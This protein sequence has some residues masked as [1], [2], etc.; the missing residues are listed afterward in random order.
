MPNPALRVLTDFRQWGTTLPVW[1]GRL[2]KEYWLLAAENIHAQGGRL[3]ALWG[4]DRR[5]EEP[6]H[7][8]HAAFLSETGI[9][10]TEMIVDPAVAS[11]PSL[12]AIFPGALR[13]ERALYDLLG[14]RAGNG[15]TRPWLRHAAWPADQ[16]PLRTDF[17][18]ENLSTAGDGD[19]AFVSAASPDA[20][21][22]PVGPIHA[23]IIEP[24]HFRFQVLGE[25]ILHLEER[26]GYTHKG[27]ERLLQ[28]L[29]VESG[30]RLAGRISGDSTVAYAW[31]YAQAVEQIAA[32]QVP[33]RAQW[34][35]AL[36]LERERLANHLGDIGALGND[37][38]LAFALTQF[39][40]LKEDLLR[41]NQRYIGHR[42]LMDRI[43]PGGV[44]F[45][46][47][48]VAV[49]A[50]RS[51]GQALGTAVERLQE[52]LAE[53]G[54]L[55]D[56]VV[57]LGMIPPERA[58]QL[59]LMGVAGRASGQPWDQRIQFPQPPYDQIQVRMTTATE[60]DVAA[61]M[62]VR[63]LEIFESL[64]LQEE[65]LRKLPGGN[66]RQPPDLRDAVGEGVGWVEGWRGEVFFWLRL[67]QGH[68]RR[69]HPQDP[70]WTLWPALEEAVL[71]DIVADF[72]LINK[73]FNL[74]YS[75][76][77]L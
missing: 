73:S 45:D 67:E 24:G 72:P 21:E 51:A 32:M 55:R 30:A 66:V 3:L 33:E 29:D 1:S 35:R 23:G 59:G 22:I 41:E 53:H 62:A 65:I 6:G 54:G 38:G 47:T 60:G 16:F 20:H 27:V 44:D 61:R 26:F 52:I 75:G 74:S 39:Q 40:A 9:V 69:C 76:H 49:A 63:F 25:E 58:A 2:C 37:A 56:R 12:T 7:L 50:L 14:I 77:D 68:I 28:G 4:E 46:L 17:R 15:D 36:C 18:A 70:S 8:V 57:R 43:L 31:S 64:R 19:Y 71:R 13:M 5:T 34:L 10:H 42:Y 11:C 48:A